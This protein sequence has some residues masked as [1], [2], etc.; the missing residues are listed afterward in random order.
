MEA[1]IRV[2]I[3]TGY[4]HGRTGA[5]MLDWPGAFC[6]GETRAAALARVPSAVHRFRDWLV[7]HGEKAADV[8]LEIEIVDEVAA[9]RL[10]GHEI[11]ATFPAD[12]RAIIGQEMERHVGRL[13]FARQDL[14]ELVAKARQA[15]AAGAA[16]EQERRSEEAA[17]RGA[18]S[19]RDVDDVLRHLA[20]AETWFISRLDSES[21]YVGPREPLDDYLVASRDFLV[22]GLRR[23]QA[24]D[25]GA[26]RTDGKGERWTLAK[27]LR[28]SLY[29]SLDHLDEIDRRLAIAERRAE[30]VELRRNAPLDPGE[31]RRLFAATGLSR[32]ARDSDDVTL[33]MV[34]GA[35]ESVSAWDGERLIGF[36]RII[37]DE[38][39]NGY[40]STIVV[41]PRWQERGLGRRLMGALMEGREE[42]KLTLDARPGSETFYGRF[43]FSAV[44]SVLVRQR[45]GPD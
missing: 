43:G 41:A 10:G 38:A 4:D 20:G 11:N 6:W 37:S 25:P 18:S 7:E 24:A 26:V 22:A 2:W 29:H 1:R 33:A 21:R 9:Y 15:I 36:A 27:V 13:G 44:D 32:R 17:A 19:G 12:D 3:E 16:L 40:I 23:L 8:P 31:L 34:R 39:T 28:R 42:L 14:L 45:G 35:T 5:W 30:R